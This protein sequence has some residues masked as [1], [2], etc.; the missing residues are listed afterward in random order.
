MMTEICTNQDV[1]NL[2]ELHSAYLID[3]N[4]NEIRITREMIERSCEQL[5]LHHP[6]AEWLA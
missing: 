4:G 2:D 6:V 5:D 3:D 1:L